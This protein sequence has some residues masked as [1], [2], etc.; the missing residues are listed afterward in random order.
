[1]PIIAIVV[2]FVGV[3]ALFVGEESESGVMPF[4]I[5][6]IILGM[7]MMHSSNPTM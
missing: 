3:G 6:L 5:G 2:L 4:G 7:A 1:M